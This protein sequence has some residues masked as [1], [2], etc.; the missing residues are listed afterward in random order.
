MLV[1]AY[2]MT[3]EEVIVIAETLR[4]GFYK[5]EIDEGGWYWLVFSDYAGCYSYC[6]NSWVEALKDAG[7]TG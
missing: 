4:P 1:G 3:T 7:W 5:A 2:K 6:G